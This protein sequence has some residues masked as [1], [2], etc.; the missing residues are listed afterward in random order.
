[1]RPLSSP[2]DC[3][4]KYR[5][6]TPS[7][8]GKCYGALDEAKRQSV[9]ISA[10]FFDEATGR[11][12]PYPGTRLEIYNDPLDE[13]S[14]TRSAFAFGVLLGSGPIKCMALA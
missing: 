6:V 12:F 4:R 2:L 8:A 9:R 11:F 10:G 13:E 3:N 7:R 1:M 14:E 5:F